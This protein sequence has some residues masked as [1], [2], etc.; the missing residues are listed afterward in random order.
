MTF[1]LR[2]LSLRLEVESPQSGTFLIHLKKSVKR[3]QK[4]KTKFVT[5][6]IL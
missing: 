4:T 3:E 2:K 1:E 6:R 5:H